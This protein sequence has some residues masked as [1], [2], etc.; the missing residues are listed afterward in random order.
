[1]EGW[2]IG[3]W[4]ERCLDEGGRGAGWSAWF[5]MGGAICRQ[6]AMGSLGVD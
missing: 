4:G 1:V 2:V 5:E 3:R 6:R